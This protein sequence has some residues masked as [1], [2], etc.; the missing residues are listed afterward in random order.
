MSSSRGK[1]PRKLANQLLS[2]RSTGNYMSQ[3][4]GDTYKSRYGFKDGSATKVVKVDLSRPIS[5]A[6]IKTIQTKENNPSG[7][8]VP[9]T[10]V[11]IA[12]DVDKT[13]ASVK[14][15]GNPQQRIEIFD[16]SSKHPAN[17][18]LGRDGYRSQPLK[19]N[20]S[21]SEINANNTPETYS[22]PTPEAVG[23]AT[24]TL[25][26]RLGRSLANK[27]A[28]SSENMDRLKGE[29]QKS[30]THLAGSSVSGADRGWHY[31]DAQSL[32]S[33]HI[34]HD[35]NVS[36]RHVH[37]QNASKGETESICEYLKSL[38][39]EIEHIDTRVKHMMQGVKAHSQTVVQETDRTKSP[40][41]RAISG[42]KNI[43]KTRG[44][45]GILGAS[46]NFLKRDLIY[47]PT[48]TSKSRLTG[49]VGTSVSKHESNIQQTEKSK[50]NLKDSVQKVPTNSQEK[51][52]LSVTQA[53]VGQAENINKSTSFAVQKMVVPKTE[54]ST[55]KHLVSL[56]NALKMHNR[57]GSISS[58]RDPSNQNTVVKVRA[59]EVRDN[60]CSCACKGHCTTEMKGVV[61]AT[62]LQNQVTPPRKLH[63]DQTAV[64]GQQSADKTEADYQPRKPLELAKALYQ[65]ELSRLSSRELR[66]NK[67]LEERAA[68]EIS[69]CT[70]KPNWASRVRYHGDTG[71]LERQALWE[72][73]RRRKTELWQQTIAAH[74][75][76]GCTFVPYT[77]EPG[78]VVA[79]PPD[80]LYREQMSWLE[81][82]CEKRER[83]SSVLQEQ[84]SCLQLSHRPGL[85]P[86]AVIEDTSYDHLVVKK[87]E[88]QRL[89]MQ[90]LLSLRK[91]C[92]T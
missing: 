45:I 27:G 36:D 71:F 1:S 81:S 37:Q 13:Q 62:R 70:F 90:S 18:A 9:N 12:S 61:Q 72:E 10:K 23:Q 7:Q 51:E 17:M 16:G 14:F 49:N 28:N 75:L 48:T 34:L 4:G 5:A 79:D 66:K 68:A 50:P 74:E 42:L 73:N 33:Q 24:S 30:V 91:D 26:E 57:T 54:R 22:R 32:D 43:G 89:L 44:P 82:V 25:L 56:R 59:E 2:S 38:D 40:G 35:Q 67:I 77:N 19:V 87:R 31:H 60:S 78:A 41:K 80:R 85:V 47:K 83:L 63:S 65:R 8:V 88:S 55:P 86:R 69:Q 52:V 76:D 21:I 46:I 29:A 84:E 3:G 15:S 6:S 53:V 20:S 58:R 39:R 11:G 92:P 64:P